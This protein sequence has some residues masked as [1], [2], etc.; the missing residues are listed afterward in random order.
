MSGKPKAAAAHGAPGDVWF[1]EA[2]TKG[3]SKPHLTRE[4]IIT[5]AVEL[6]DAQGVQHLSMRNLAERLQA[7][8]TSLYWHVATKD[9]VLDLAL[10]TVFAEIRLPAGHHASWREDVVTFMTELRRVLLRH[11]WAAPLA[12]SRPL[13]GPHALSRSEFVYAALI[14]AGFTGPDL[15]AAA[16][17]ITTYVTG[18]ASS[19]AVWQ[20]HDEADVRSA[21]HDHL[22]THQTR[23]PALADH[24][25]LSGGDWTAHFTRG[26]NFLLDGLSA[27]SPG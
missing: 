17:A 2:K 6:L 9:D 24:F 12:N 21:V 15:S 13:V 23:Y 18:T 1:R 5:A 14:T 11:P 8:A 3:R 22:Q 4:K 20:Q 10:D 7:H 16:A 27:N 26:M 19:E 25:P